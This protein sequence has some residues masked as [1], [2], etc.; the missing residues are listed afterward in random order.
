MLAHVTQAQGSAERRASQ[1]RASSPRSRPRLA[2]GSRP[3]SPTARQPRT[4]SKP[5]PSSIPFGSRVGSPTR[6]GP[7]SRAATP[8]KRLGTSAAGAEEDGARGAGPAMPY[9]TA[10]MGAQASSGTGGR[11]EAI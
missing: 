6:A 2:F 5:A 7:C 1:T 11:W 4:A 9:R 3:S 10:F 8:A